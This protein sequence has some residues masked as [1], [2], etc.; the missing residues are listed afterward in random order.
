[1]EKAFFPVLPGL[2]GG[3]AAALADDLVVPGRPDQ[4][5]PHRLAMLSQSQEW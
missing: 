1:M 5:L 2:A 4:P 3:A